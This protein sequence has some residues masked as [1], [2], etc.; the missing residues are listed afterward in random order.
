MNQICHSAFSQID[1]E[2]DGLLSARLKAVWICFEYRDT[3]KGLHIFANLTNLNHSS[4]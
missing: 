2:K 3:F 1:P 4:F